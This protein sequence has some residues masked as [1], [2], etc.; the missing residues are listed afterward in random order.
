[1]AARDRLN[2]LNI[3]RNVLAKTYGGLHPKMKKINEEITKQES[4]LEIL[5][6][7][8]EKSYGERVTLLKGELSTVQ[9]AIEEW[10]KKAIEA[11]QAEAEFS[12]LKD[13]LARS[14]ELSKRLVDSLQNLDVQKGMDA[15]V[16]QILQ[17]AGKPREIR[18]NL[19]TETTR[20]VFLGLVVGG[21]IFALL[22]RLD[23]RAYTVEESQ[24]QPWRAIGRSSNYPRLAVAQPAP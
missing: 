21:G 1:V 3:E 18:A 14:Q 11:S 6:A 23:R 20:A 4:L 15:D 24:R 2:Q 16:L 9:V 13:S 8:S 7:E 17:Y 12:R 5:T 10:E 19:K 22:L